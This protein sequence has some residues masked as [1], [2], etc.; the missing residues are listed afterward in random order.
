[1]TKIGSF[2]YVQPFVSFGVGMFISH[3]DIHLPAVKSNWSLTF[4]P[5]VVKGRWKGQPGE[6]E[7][8]EPGL[9]PE[10]SSSK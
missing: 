8:E 10:P 5:P 9:H 6:E 3:V 4:V 1:M 7:E 2:A